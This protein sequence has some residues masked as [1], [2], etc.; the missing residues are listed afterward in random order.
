MEYTAPA[1]PSTIPKETDSDKPE[2]PSKTTKKSAENAALM[3]GSPE[4][5]ALSQA[6]EEDPVHQLVANDLYAIPAH[7]RGRPQKTTSNA[8]EVV[9]K[10]YA[11]KVQE[12]CLNENPNVSSDVSN[13]KGV[14]LT[15]P[16]ETIN[17]NFPEI[18]QSLK[19]YFDTLAPLGIHLL[20]LHSETYSKCTYADISVNKV[21]VR[22]I[23]DRRDPI[24]IGSTCLVQKLGLAPDIA[25]RRV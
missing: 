11:A 18:G 13:L 24:N 14:Q 21:K 8:V 3:K 1:I 19:Q 17:N 2:E 23:I 6:F 4:L 12:T 7:G 10:P 22:A 20:N 25:H 16:L 15:M 5:F 9:S